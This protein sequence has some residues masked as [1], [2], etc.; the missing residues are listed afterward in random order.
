MKLLPTDHP[1]ASLVPIPH[2]GSAPLDRHPVAVY[3]ASLSP[4]SRRSMAQALGRIAEL[5]SAGAC[6]A[7]SLPWASLR[8]AHTTAIRSMLAEQSSPAT[9]N[10]MLS[11]LR[12]VLKECWRL[13]AM[14]A[15]EYQ[16]AVDLKAAPG[17]RL[18]AG[19]MLTTGELTSLFRSCA[20]DGT[21]G[22]RLDAAILALLVGCGL[23][24]S[25]SA[26]L[27]L[28]DYDADE[29]E[30]RLRSA[31][32]NRQR[33]VPIVNGQRD[34]IESWLEVRGRDAGP[35]LCPVNKAG[36]IDLRRMTDQALYMRLRSRAERAQVQPFTP[37]DLRRTFVSALLDHG[38]D[39][40]S[41][42]RLAGHASVTTTTR[43]DRRDEKAKRQAAELLHVPFV[44]FRST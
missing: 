28:D 37:H 34:A 33:I 4:G 42:Q 16:R 30:L 27:D 35:L 22:A 43:Y 19:R 26:A 12:G 44:A 1:I 8:Y 29:G 21:S 3:L 5:A 13:G 11:A 32:G 14:P 40:S 15:E 31:K 20:A 24:R 7:E 2:S 9:A 6:T 17:R 38:A 25:E 39:I 18:L 41:V 23:R 10:R 36:T